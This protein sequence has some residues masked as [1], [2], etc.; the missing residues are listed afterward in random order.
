MNGVQRSTVPEAFSSGMAANTSSG[1]FAF[2][3]SPRGAREVR[4]R[5]GRGGADQQIATSQHAISPGVIF[6]AKS[7]GDRGRR[8]FRRAAT[9][10][11]RD[12]SF[13][14]MP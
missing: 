4:Q 1:Y 8:S 7:G 9:A 11:R 2:Q 10:S 6:V 3:S 14:S 13:A 12:V 5:R